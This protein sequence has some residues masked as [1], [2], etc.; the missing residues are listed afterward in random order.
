MAFVSTKSQIKNTI[1]NYIS[2]LVGKTLYK[3][4]EVLFQ[5]CCD[6]TGTANV[7]CEDDGDYAITIKTTPS[8]GFLGKGVAYVIING[9]FNTGIVT[10]PNEIFIENADPGVGTYDINVVVFLPTSSDGNVGVFKT[11]TIPSVEFPTCI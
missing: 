1:L 4:I 9:Y 7:V 10:E 11:F 8:I 3:A 2:R 5:P 6:I